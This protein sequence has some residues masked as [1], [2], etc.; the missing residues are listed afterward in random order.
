MVAC[1]CEKEKFHLGSVQ[2][3]VS[4]GS[5]AVAHPFGHSFDETHAAKQVCGHET[6]AA[7]QVCGLGL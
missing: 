1:A 2:R 5:G 7:K 3:C 6:D 4:R